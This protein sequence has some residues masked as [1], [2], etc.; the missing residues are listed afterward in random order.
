MSLFI[1]CSEISNN[2][3][4]S[5]S[6][7]LDN[8]NTNIY[9]SNDEFIWPLPGIHRITSY[10]GP[11]KA[12][13][14]G[15]STYHSGID[16]AAVQNTNIYSVLSGKVIFTGFKGAG[17]YT[18]TISSNNFLISYCHVSPNFIIKPRRYCRKKFINW[19]SWS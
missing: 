4:K 13:A 9:F 5:N 7:E 17:G 8:S 12:P 18:I 19:A 6:T 11:R 10:F 3:N 16:I 14:K 1:Y 2:S 15:S